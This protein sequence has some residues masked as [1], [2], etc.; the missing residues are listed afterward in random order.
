[1]FSLTHR[2]Q[3]TVLL[4]TQ[5][6]I[7]CSPC[8]SGFI[9]ILFSL[10]PRLQ[11]TVL[12]PTQAS[13]YCSPS[14]TTPRCQRSLHPA[15]GTAPCLTGRTSG[16][17]SRATP[18][19]TAHWQRTRW[20]AR[21]LQRNADWASSRLGTLATSSSCPQTSRRPGTAADSSVFV[22]ERACLP[23][24]RQPSGTQLKML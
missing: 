17:T 20:T 3:Y 5:V 24:T 22:R 21:T 11:D 19:R 16:S 7:Y 8:H 9:K 15:S 6:S 23:S 14:T 4:N 10:P 2:F 12:L 13:R 18:T 1:M